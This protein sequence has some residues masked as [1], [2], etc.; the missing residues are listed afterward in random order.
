MAKRKKKRSVFELRLFLPIFLI[1]FFIF[2]AQIAHADSVLMN[3]LGDKTASAFL[4]VINL[5]L[6]A[7]FQIAG[8]T[9]SLGATLLEFVLNPIAFNGLFN[10]AAVYNLWRMVRDFFNLFFILMILFIAF[11][12]IFQVQA[13]NYKKL[14]WQLVLM[15][16]LTNFSFPVSRFIIDLANVPMYFFLNSIAP[17]AGNTVGKTISGNLFSAAELK[18]VLLPSVSET[19]NITGASD[20]TNRLLQAVIFIFIFGVSLTVLAV[21]LL[22][23]AVTLL[24]LVIFSPI[25]FIG[26]AIPW[27]SSISKK[28]WDQLLSFRL[29]ISYE[30][31][32]LLFEQL[33]F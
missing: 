27:L 29:V 4:Y 11:A 18:N 3:W 21:L 30:F 9:V 14:L 6:Y 28:W 1:G 23:R 24:V 2:S 19:A 10:L 20:M 16:L 22:V 26:S 12:T 32:E 8:L 31:G 13:Y 15:A 25:G 17:T 33:V 7:V 5:V